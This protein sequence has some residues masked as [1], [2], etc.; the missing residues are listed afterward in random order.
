M[1]PHHGSTHGHGRG[2]FH[3]H[4]G[5]GLGHGGRARRGDVPVA[6]MAL[7]AESDM[8]GYQIIQEIADR[9]DGAWTPSPGS[10]YP[11]L[12]LLQDQGMVASEK[13]GGKRVF[14]LT[15]TGRKH[16]AMI[17][18]GAPWS[19]IAKEPDAVRR[20]RESFASLSNAVAQIGRAGTPDQVERSVEVL[21]EARRTL[22]AML[23]G[24]E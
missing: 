2:A 8:H 13:V 23:A 1:H 17:P 16:A 5:A 4:G 15:E 11:V 24:D 10:I 12:Q 19:G 6:V 18:E 22:Y 21:G 7:L 14:S 3:G 20:L 9:T